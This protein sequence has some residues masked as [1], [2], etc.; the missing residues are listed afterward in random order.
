MLDDAFLKSVRYNDR[1]LPNEGLDKL[2]LCIIRTRD[3]C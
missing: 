1:C 2:S 3:A